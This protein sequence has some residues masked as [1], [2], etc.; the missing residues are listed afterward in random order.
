[1]HASFVIYSVDFANIRTTPNARLQPFVSRVPSVRHNQ[2]D[3]GDDRPND[4]DESA[5][6]GC[7]HRGRT[8]T[9]WWCQ[10]TQYSSDDDE[11]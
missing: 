9:R 1:M 8:S 4:D 2:T 3:D 7:K 5:D 6:A 10:G 11:G